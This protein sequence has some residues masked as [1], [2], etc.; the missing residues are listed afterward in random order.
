[1]RDPEKR[2]M[3]ADWMESG[4]YARSPAKDVILDRPNLTFP[5]RPPEKQGSRLSIL[6]ARPVMINASAKLA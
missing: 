3:A 4:F 5:T 1:M 2:G 6:M